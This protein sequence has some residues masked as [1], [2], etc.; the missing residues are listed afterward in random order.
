MHV[1]E[2]LWEE[3]TVPLSM[4]LMPSAAQWS[5]V[6]GV[7]QECGLDSRPGLRNFSVC[8]K[9]LEVQKKNNA[10]SRFF[11]WKLG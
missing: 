5:K 7:Q 9:K 1:C 6:T 8:E 2:E 4:N 10:M 11:Y 3:R